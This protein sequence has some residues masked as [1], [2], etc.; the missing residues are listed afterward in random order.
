MLAG[1]G[2]IFL[3]EVAEIPSSLQAKLLQAFQQQDEPH[4]GADEQPEIDVRIIGATRKDP[5]QFVKNG[6]F[7]EDLFYRLDLFSL[8]LPPL[9]G[10][11]EDICLLVN[12]FL[13][14]NYNAGG[15]KALAISPEVMDIFL[16][17]HWPGN[18]RQLENVIK[19]AVDAGADKMIGTAHLPQEMRKLAKGNGRDL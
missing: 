11:R 17:H 5:D 16:E 7:R 19:G 6:A 1:G 18:V 15:E 12:H 13:A 2:T 9:R 10:R 4:G 14:V 3:D 8:K